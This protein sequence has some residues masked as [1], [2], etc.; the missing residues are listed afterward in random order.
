VWTDFANDVFFNNLQSL[1]ALFTK[2]RAKQNTNDTLGS[3]SGLTRETV[4]KITEDAKMKTLNPVE[5][6]VMFNLSQMTVLDELNDLGEYL[7][8]DFVEFLELIVRLAYLLFKATSPN[9]PT[10]D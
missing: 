4:V 8:M 1:M 6:K 9:Q 5:T 7:Q 2:Y 10:Q 3:N